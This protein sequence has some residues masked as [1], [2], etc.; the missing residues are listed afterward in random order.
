MKKRLQKAMN[1]ELE[2]LYKKETK[3][4]PAVAPRSKGA[5]LVET[6]DILRVVYDVYTTAQDTNSADVMVNLLFL[7]GSGMN[8]S[9]WEYYAAYLPKYIGSDKN[10]SIHKIVTMDQVTH[11]DSAELNR[12]QLGVNFDWADGARDACRVAEA[13]FMPKRSPKCINIVIG[14]SMGGFQALCCGVLSPFMFDQIIVIEPVV[15]VPHVDNEEGVTIVPPKFHKALLSKMDDTFE[16]M[17]DFKTFMNTRS[18]YR[19]SH[20]EIV[21]R[22]TNFEAVALPNGRV[23]AKISKEQNIICYLTLDPTAKW[24]IG[25]LPYIKTPV[26]GIVG[27]VSTWCPPENQQL[28]VSRLPEYH[29]DFIPK[30]DHLVNLED[31]ESCLQ[32]ITGYISDYI[33]KIDLDSGTSTHD[34]PITSDSHRKRLFARKFSQF[35]N[36]RVKDGDII[37]AKL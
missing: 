19:N 22:M 1:A 18:F 37:L 13:E 23:R 17:D 30:G 15:Y 25:S 32:K 4:A 35:E 29:Q 28:L 36:E 26:Y 12:S 3:I 10:R 33:S 7:H 16:C 5:V 11:G 9:I 24:L 34:P 27:G 31:P 21:E 20:P 6:E 14:H 2:K 8:R